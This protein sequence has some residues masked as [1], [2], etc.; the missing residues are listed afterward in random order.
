MNKILNIVMVLFLRL[1]L[2][3]IV[4]GLFGLIVFDRFW[5]T[6]SLAFGI[7]FILGYLINMIF[8]SVNTKRIIEFEKMAMEHEKTQSITVNCAYCNGM[9]QI[10]LTL[11]VNRFDCKFCRKTNRLFL[12][13]KTAQIT[14]FDEN[15]G[16]PTMSDAIITEMPK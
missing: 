16:V 2:A 8:S 1:C 10:P 11:N 15:A 3:P 4:I 13:F 9:N 12:Q 7:N 5:A 6:F 14:E